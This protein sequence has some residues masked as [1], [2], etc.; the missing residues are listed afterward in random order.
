MVRDV[1]CHLPSG[2]GVCVC[3]AHVH[4]EGRTVICCLA[5]TGSR[6]PSGPHRVPGQACPHFRCL[7]G[8]TLLGPPAALVPIQPDRDHLPSQQS[9]DARLPVISVSPQ[10]PHKMARAGATSRIQSHGERQCN[11]SKWPS[12]QQGLPGSQ[13]PFPKVGSPNWCSCLKS[14]FSK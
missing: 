2:P 8:P 5:R 14:I 1:H 12:S 7:P 13:G 6:M 11:L 9:Q 4:G 10:L 3:V